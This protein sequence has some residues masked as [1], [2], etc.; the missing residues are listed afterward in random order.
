MARPVSARVREV[1]RKLIE[2]LHGHADHPGGRFLSNRAIAGQ[3]AVSYQTADRIVRELVEAGLLIRRAAS[4]TFVPGEAFSLGGAVLLFDQ[5][6]KRPASFGAR[7]LFSLCAAMDRNRVDWRVRWI[8]PT[9]PIDLPRLL[10]DRFPVLWNVPGLIRPIVASGRRALILN[11]RAP[12]GVEATRIDSVEIDDFSGG[13]CAAQLLLGRSKVLRPAF[14]IVTGPADDVRSQ[15]R[16]KG[17]LEQS[18]AT[19]VMAGGWDYELGVRVAKQA[20]D[21]GTDG[22]FCCND[23][24]AH[25]LVDYAKKQGTRLPPLVGFDN[26][27]VAERMGMTTIAIPFAE[28]S[29]AAAELVQ[30][31]LIDNRST[32]SHRV[33][34]PRPIVRWV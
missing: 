19:L 15:R 3:Y 8:D 24:L 14:A 28:L 11:D 22:V 33:F 30:M 34:A 21:A 2:R 5:R 1:K 32:A 23:R 7:L 4:G 6:G 29:D 25:A 18:N 26:A 10:N 9:R 20:I 13:A 16:V 31:R 17:F 12:S 27:P